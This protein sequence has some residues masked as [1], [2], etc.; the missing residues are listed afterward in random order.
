MR[1]RFIRV[2]LEVS[3]TWLKVLAE[4][5]ASIVPRQAQDKEA[6]STGPPAAR[7]PAE[8]VAITSALRRYFDSCEYRRALCCAC[9]ITLAFGGSLVFLPS[10][11]LRHTPV[12]VARNG[13]NPKRTD[14]EPTTH[15]NGRRMHP[16]TLRSMA[17][18]F[19]AAGMCSGF[20]CVQWVQLP[21]CEVR[22]A[23]SGQNVRPDPAGLC[24]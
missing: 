23:L 4:L 16:S 12:P 21:C 22:F 8:V 18:T 17:F 24:I 19:T 2:S 7:Y 10:V 14:G 20:S 3:I 15:A 6:A 13:F 11:L 9:S 1:V 5:D